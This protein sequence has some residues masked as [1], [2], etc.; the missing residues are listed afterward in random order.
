VSLVRTADALVITASNPATRTSYSE[1][2][3]LLGVRERVAAHG[4]QMSAAG[5]ADGRFVLR[6]SLPFGTADRT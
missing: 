2:Y 5:E 6:A 3:G 1:G 4:G